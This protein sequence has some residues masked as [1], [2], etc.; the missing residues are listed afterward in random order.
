MKYLGW[1]TVILLF[2]G[3]SG[4]YGQ[5]ASVK[6]GF[7][8]IYYPNGK[9]SS[10]GMMKSN[11]PDGYWK[12]YYPS[13]I[14]KS[15]G[16]RR[17]HLLDS[18]WVFYNESG[19]TLQKV[20]YLM[21][22]KNGFVF[23]YEYRNNVDP[24]RKGFIKAKEL[25]VNDKKAGKSFYYYDNGKTHEITEFANSKKNGSSLEYDRDG[26]LITV[27]RYI[28]GSLV[29]RQR[30]N[31]TDAAGKKQGVWRTFHENG[32]VSS[33]ALYKDDVLNGSFKEYDE[34]GTVKV[35]LQYSNGNLVVQ[36]DTAELDVE[37][38][39]RLNDAG[40]VIYSG[41]YRKDVPVGIHRSYDDNGKVIDAV[42]YDND[43]LKLGSGILTNEG[44]KE[45]AW[46]YFW[47]DGSIKS[48]GSYTNNQEN[49]KWRYLFRNGREEQEGLFKN[50]KFEGLWQ[51]YYENGNLKREDEYFS[52][53]EEGSYT[54]Y[55]SV[56]NIIAKGSYFDGMKE[57][58]WYYKVNDYEEK[59]SYK[60]DLK[61][62]KWQAFYADGKLKYEGS[63]LQGN[64]DGE[65]K[66]YFPD[67]KL[68]EIEYYVMGIAEKNWKKYDQ[69]GNI[70]LT[71]TY[72]DNRE[73][74]INGEKV[75]FA[76]DDVKLIQ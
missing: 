51:W 26:L 35:Y 63:F 73:F 57:G 49:G 14:I 59:G 16:N 58:E 37:V 3:H 45:G 48:S 32:R 46:K 43:G 19:D 6:D 66:F 72:K 20:N 50:G 25:Y 23:E 15:E 9:V 41:T 34:N 21:G 75:E 33:E 69:A 60:G 76:D 28:D 38:R 44:K 2:F 10:E 74:R 61:E 40:N 71:V 5:Q 7:T 18:L 1:L 12:T 17:N 53:K 62:G 29:E 64:P 31:R 55:D 47:P 39:T 68:K 27:E 24:M 8:K 30:I 67:G 54:E 42:I 11:L 65:H 52:G 22:K 36:N 4:V 13:G 56:G 70:L